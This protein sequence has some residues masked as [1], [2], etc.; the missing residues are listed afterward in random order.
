LALRDLEAVARG[1]GGGR[2]YDDLIDHTIEVRLGTLAVRVTKRFHIAS[3]GRSKSALPSKVPVFVLLIFSTVGANVGVCRG[4]PQLGFLT[5]QRVDSVQVIDKSGMEP[6][7]ALSYS[8]AISRTG[9][10]AALRFPAGCRDSPNNE[11]A[12]ASIMQGASGTWASIT[13]PG[14]IGA[15]PGVVAP[16]LAFDRAGKL[17][18]A[19]IAEEQTPKGPVARLLVMNHAYDGTVSKPVVLTDALTSEIGS[20]SILSRRKN[21]LDVV[22]TD[23]RDRAFAGWFHP[24]RDTYL[25]L[26]SRSLNGD[27]LSETNR[28]IRKSGKFEVFNAKIRFGPDGDVYAIWDQ[29]SHEAGQQIYLGRGDGENWTTPVR[30]SDDKARWPHAHKYFDVANLPNGGALVLWQESTSRRGIRWRVY[31]QDKLGEI[32][33]LHDQAC[34]LSLAASRSGTIHLV[35][36]DEAAFRTPAGSE[37]P[38]QYGQKLFYSAFRFGKWIDVRE[39]AANVLRDTAAAAV[40]QDGHLHLTWQQHESGRA[41]LIHAVV[42]EP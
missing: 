14:W 18:I 3:F 32:G 19:W 42:D 37:A 10:L 2:T 13:L 26:F 28:V 12:G 33:R 25:H 6:C 34:C 21:Q 29:I 30:V 15:A 11:R 38:S 7:P 22:W 40:D 4:E 27:S 17:F 36:Q 41:Q 31:D 23:A 39:V 24:M 35:F 8:V 5:K 16:T 1:Q 20:V 9:Q